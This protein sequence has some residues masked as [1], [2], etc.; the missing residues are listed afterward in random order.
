MASIPPDVIPARATGMSLR[1]KILLIAL[2]L[3]VLGF[4]VW[5]GLRYISHDR[6]MERTDNAYVEADISV[7]SPKVQGYVREVL[8]KDN[9][10]VRKGDVLAI[11]DDSEY[12][13]KLAQAEAAVATRRAAI[14]NVKASAERQ[15]SAIASAQ[16]EIEAKRADWSRAD[17]DLKRFSTLRKD[18]W[19]SEQ[20]YQSAQADAARSHANVD[21][22]QADL[23][24]Q[25]GQMGVLSS[26]A[27]VVLAGYKE[28]LA[29][30]EVA[31]LDV[32][33]TI[34]RAPADGVIGNR[35]VRIGQYARAGSL[36]MAVVPMRDVYVVANFKETQLQKI[37]VG[38]AV[39]LTVDAYADNPLAGVVDSISPAAGSRFSILPPENATGNFTKIVQRMA[40]KIR[41]TNALPETVR[42]VPGMSV[43]AEID[44][45]SEPRTAAGS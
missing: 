36:L 4:A 19:I 29:A 3:G 18:K 31:R 38:Q 26:Q 45:R 43:E 24:G 37:R 28:S 23:R 27:R 5:R 15:K 33:N 8:V 21:S 14:E 13:A 40:V 42:L 9:Q 16:S 2:V 35:S 12:R 11:M 34:L 30:L 17:S 22:A 39:A 32:E 1:R 7:I 25:Q 44:T 6:Y 20:R 41:L 10:P